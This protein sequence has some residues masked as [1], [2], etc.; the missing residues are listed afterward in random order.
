MKLRFYLITLVC[1]LI[2][3]SE[4]TT[5]S[6]DLEINTSD[7]VGFKEEKEDVTEVLI[8]DGPLKY[9]KTEVLEPLIL[10]FAG[11]IMAHN[12]N[13]NMKD[14]NVIYQNVSHIFLSD[15][16]TF[17]NLETPVTD[18]LPL[19]TYPN[20]NVH[21][22]YLL[23][24]VAAGFDVFALANNHSNDQGLEG[25]D[26]TLSAMENIS[27]SIFSSGLKKNTDDPFEPL[28]IE[29][30][31]WKILFLSVTE[32]LN[33]HD[34]AA[35]RVYYIPPTQA[36]RT[37][38]LKEIINIKE[39]HQCDVF[40]LS[41][42][43]NEPEYIREVSNKKR[44]WFSQLCEAGV[45]ILWA[46]HPHVMQ[47]WE[48]VSLIDKG[49]SQEKEALIMFSM[50][51]FISG[52][53]YTPNIDNPAAMREYTGDSVLLR[54]TL[55]KEHVASQATISFEPILIT[56]VSTRGF[57]V[58]VHHL[59]E[60]FIA[61]QKGIWKNYYQKRFNLMHAYFPL[62]PMKQVTAILE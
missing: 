27:P 59:D 36:A 39:T 62:L 4:C 56:N 20:F 31:E 24:A 60:V 47:T 53:R 49:T 16:L 13:F 26:G 6:S 42:H 1:A 5:V 57:G 12:V 2:V 48:K 41:L 11:D 15:D 43:S 38:F 58:S 28:V 29:K 10:T 3:L 37:Q 45:D 8:E 34:T 18:S 30:N 51:N 7:A 25:I 50:G 17:G 52:Q 44:V 46:H 21:S 55:E 40:I 22:N 54:V 9:I 61:S 19:S 32:I 23:A 33:A 35:K 14:Y